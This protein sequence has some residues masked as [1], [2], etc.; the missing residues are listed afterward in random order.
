MIC[1]S[2]RCVHRRISAPLRPARV[3]PRRPLPSVELL[4]AVRLRARHTGNLRRGIVRASETAVP[5]VLPEE[6]EVRLRDPHSTFAPPAPIAMQHDAHGLRWRQENSVAKL[7][8]Y[9]A[10]HSECGIDPDQ[11]LMSAPVSA[12]IQLHPAP[13]NDTDLRFRQPLCRTGEF[14]YRQITAL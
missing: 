3:F 8:I 1:S 9:L 7:R 4:R 10:C 11:R 14:G 2:R 12:L 13:A 5:Q 6:L